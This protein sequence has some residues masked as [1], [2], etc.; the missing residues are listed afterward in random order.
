M[1]WQRILAAMRPA[2]TLLA[3]AAHAER[4]AFFAARSLTLEPLEPR[5]LLAADLA[6]I[7]P[8]VSFHPTVHEVTPLGGASPN[9]RGYSPSQIRHAYGLDQVMFGSVR[10]DGSGQTIAIIDAY[11]SPTI[12]HDLHAF[13]VAFGLPDPPS[14]RV[15]AQDGS[16]NYP[17]TD[18]SGRG[19][20]NWETETA[21]D[22]E[23]AHALAPGADLLLVEGNAPT[24]EDLIETAVNFARRQP[25]V[26]VISMSFGSG[27]FS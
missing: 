4:R 27:E 5:E 20:L 26:S 19:T 16:A 23:W 25:G 10:G 2:R 18:P 15:V 21:L 13:D 8:P 24:S 22:V 7:L 9:G 11:H 6:P 1:L 17:R 3:R 12:A 14:L